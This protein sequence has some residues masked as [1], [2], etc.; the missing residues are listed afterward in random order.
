MF[1]VN[2]KVSFHVLPRHRQLSHAIIAL[3]NTIHNKRP[4]RH[5]TLLRIPRNI[6]H[7]HA[8]NQTRDRRKES[9]QSIPRQR[10]GAAFTPSAFP[11]HGAAGHHREAVEHEHDKADVFEEQARVTAGESR[12]EAD[13]A[14][15]HLPEEGGERVVAEGADD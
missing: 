3:T 11:D 4:T 8:H 1:P 9:N 13:C 7:A 10:C 5:K 15:G 2:K 14:Q 6:C 12:D